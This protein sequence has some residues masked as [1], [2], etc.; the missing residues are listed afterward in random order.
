MQETPMGNSEM[1]LNR[2]G[3]SG[4]YERENT[5]GTAL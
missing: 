5:F 1:G 3:G 2:K 4:S